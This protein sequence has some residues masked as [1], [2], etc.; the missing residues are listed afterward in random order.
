MKAPRKPTPSELFFRGRP[1]D[2]RLGEWILPAQNLPPEQ[3]KKHEVVIFGYPDDHGVK[4]NRG[5][6]GAALGPEGI[7]RALYKMTV[8]ADRRWEDRFSAYDY[9][10]AVISSELAQT[11]IFAQALAA[12][13]AQSGCTGLV[14]GGGHDFAAPTFLGFHAAA[15]KARW[16][17][18]NVDPH[19][20]TRE[21]EGPAAHSG[22]PFR[23]ILDSGKIKGRDFVEFGARASRNTRS[24][25]EYCEAKGV[26]I[27]TLEALRSKP[28]AVQAQFR[29]TLTK[30]T[31][32]ARFVGVTIDLDSCSDSEGSSAAPVLGFS[33][34]ELCCF[35]AAAGANPKVRYLELA[36]AAP[37]LDTAD[38]ISRVAAEVAY[39]FLE[40]RSRLR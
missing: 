15:P 36:E 1:G 8:P 30:L 37:G 23:V 26:K 7:R 34:W 29:Q 3:R 6:A 16:G 13:V 5:R 24:S 27:H 18:I 31:K 25:W 14:F 21:L 9:G 32:T 10:D 4:K 11:H 28:T 22:N 35:A 2:I 12:E 40:A 20:D 17:L 33:T 39:A 38:R 19:L